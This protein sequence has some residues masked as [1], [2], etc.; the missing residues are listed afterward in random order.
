MTTTGSSQKV[1]SDQEVFSF[2]FLLKKA[3]KLVAVI[4]VLM[5]QKITESSLKNKSSR[6]TLQTVLFSL[7]FSAGLEDPDD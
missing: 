4:L 2:S 5:Q 1:A 3:S 7:F 6:V